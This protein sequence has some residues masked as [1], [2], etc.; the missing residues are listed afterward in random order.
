MAFV[1]RG[2][3]SSSSAATTATT[4]TTLAGAA[5]EVVDEAAGATCEFNYP[6][7]DPQ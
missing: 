6:N 1:K 5:P 3:H 4:A 2:N 7:R